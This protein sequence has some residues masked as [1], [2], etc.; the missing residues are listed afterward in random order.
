MPAR[1]FALLAQ[2]SAMAVRGHW[3]Q[4]PPGD[5]LEMLDRSEQVD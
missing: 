5:Y 3:R 2:L 1:F 4:Q